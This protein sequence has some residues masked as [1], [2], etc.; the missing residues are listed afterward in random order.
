MAQDDAHALQLAE[1]ALETFAAGMG[2][3]PGDTTQ[4]L[5]GGYERRTTV[6]ARLDLLKE[7]DDRAGVIPYE[8]EVSVA[9]RS[10]A[11][12]RSLMLSTI[13]LGAHR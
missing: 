4:V 9:W 5:D 7:T 6:R 2:L 3:A 11:R 1:S 12:Q 10:G 8:V 13:T